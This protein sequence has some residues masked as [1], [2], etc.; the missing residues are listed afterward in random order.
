MNKIRGKYQKHTEEYLFTIN[1]PMECNSNFC[2]YKHIML[3][4]NY[5]FK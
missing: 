2:S 5:L 4:D 3:N 1:Y